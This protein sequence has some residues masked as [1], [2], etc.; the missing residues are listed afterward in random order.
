MHLSLGEFRLCEV[1]ADA[2]SKQQRSRPGPRRSSRGTK[3]WV[4]EREDPA[5]AMCEIGIFF[6]QLLVD[7]RG[8]QMQAKARGI[9]V[10]ENT[11]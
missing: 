7:G 9:A 5:S 11:G 1:N 3:E 4:E 2:W 10:D 6:N 8:N